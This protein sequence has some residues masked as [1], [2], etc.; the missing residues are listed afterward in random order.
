ME[1]A[2]LLSW[3]FT[4]TV[5][6]FRPLGTSSLFWTNLIDLQS[7]SVRSLFFFELI[8]LETFRYNFRVRV[9]IIVDHLSSF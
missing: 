9:E 4:D 5:L 1:C 8:F 7:F 3:R 2:A 6:R